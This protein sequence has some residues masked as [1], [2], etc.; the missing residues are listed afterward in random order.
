MAVE[1]KV[2]WNPKYSHRITRCGRDLAKVRRHTEDPNDATCNT[3]VSLYKR[4]GIK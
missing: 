1:Y 4:L 2:H 3:C